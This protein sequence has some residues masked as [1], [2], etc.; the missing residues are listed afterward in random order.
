M[1][2]PVRVAESQALQQLEEITLQTQKNMYPGKSTQKSRDIYFGLLKIKIE[3]FVNLAV[4]YL[5]QRQWDTS[6]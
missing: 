2:N 3:L 6:D 4:V 5:N 1:K